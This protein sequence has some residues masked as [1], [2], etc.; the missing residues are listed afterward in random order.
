[1]IMNITNEL[2]L[3]MSQLIVITRQ[4]LHLMIRWCQ[5][6]VESLASSTELS[7]NNH[8]ADNPEI[9]SEE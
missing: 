8:V 7:T 5:I 9:A 1:M 6:G 2:H 3:C 4:L